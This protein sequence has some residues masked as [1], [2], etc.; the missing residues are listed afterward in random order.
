MGKI[1][2]TRLRLVSIGYVQVLLL[3]S[4]SSNPQQAGGVGFRAPCYRERKGL[5][6]RASYLP[7]VTEPE[8]KGRSL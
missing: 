3:F 8:F 6:E 2:Q 7:G 4:L 5:S 1:T